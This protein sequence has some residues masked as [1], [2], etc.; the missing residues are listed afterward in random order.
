V[1]IQSPHP[2]IR[3]ADLVWRNRSALGVDGGAGLPAKNRNL[4]HPKPCQ[5]RNRNLG[6]EEGAVCDDDYLTWGRDQIR[7]T[8]F[9][10]A[11]AI[12]SMQREVIAKVALLIL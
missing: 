10:C 5:H 8:I 2:A 6:G 4:R 11:S 9:R 12:E 1:S 3:S 7:A